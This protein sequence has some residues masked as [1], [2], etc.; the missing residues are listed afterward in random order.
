MRTTPMTHTPGPWLDC[1]EGWL[2]NPNNGAAVQTRVIEATGFGRIAEVFDISNEP[3]GNFRLMLAAPELLEALRV[4]LACPA[5]HEE[6]A[7]AAT[8]AAYDLAVD[9]I[10]KAEGRG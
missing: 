1:G 5:M 10:A 3:E 8:E 6:S 4:I 7:D 9:A 2:Q